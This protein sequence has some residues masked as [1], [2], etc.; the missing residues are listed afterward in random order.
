MN[1]DQPMSRHVRRVTAC[2]VCGQN[3]WLEILSLGLMPLANNY[4]EPAPSYEHEPHFPLELMACR[5]CWLVTLRHI[6]DPEI[7]YRHYIYIS[8][9]S[10]M[11]VRHMHQLAA[12]TI[13]RFGVPAGSL[14]VELGSNI[15]TQLEVFRDAGMRVLGIDPARNLAE[16]A[17]RKGIET[18]PEFFNAEL[19]G[20]IVQRFGRPFVILGRH[21]FA[22]IDNLRDVL[23][24][25]RAS[26]DRGGVF[27]IEV[28][29][30]VDLVGSNQFDTI[31]HE[32]LSYFSVGTFMRLFDRHGL[33][34]VDVE[35]FPVHGGSIVVFGALADSERP[36]N[37]SISDL[38]ALER[39]E[40]LAEEGYYRRFAERVEVT[41][42]AVARIVRGL[43]GG[44]K[45]VAGYGAPAKGNTLLN[46]CGLDNRALEYVSD[47][48]EFK[49]G[50]VL[51][52]THIPIKSPVYAKQHPPDCFLLLAW[53]YAKEIIGREQEY[54]KDG[55]TFIIPIPEPVVVSADSLLEGRFIVPTGPAGDGQLWTMDYKGIVTFNDGEIQGVAFK[56]LTVHRDSRGGLAELFRTDELS[57]EFRPEMATVSWTEP[58]AIRGPHEHL[59]QSNLLVFP[60]QQSFR[61][62]LWDNRETSPTY[63]HTLRRVVGGDRPISVLVPAGVVHAFQNISGERGLSLNFP[64]RLFR[65]EQRR[66][67]DGAIRHE[68]DQST[69]FKIGT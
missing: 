17:D 12:L 37:Q 60:G 56:P 23:A 49:Q 34:V 58:Q 36:A 38:L 18:W 51:P 11:I 54:L 55:G 64:N 59:D 45:R 20:R 33:R 3:D 30:L 43:A 5:S 24:G 68:Q 28:P 15:G 48:T 9:D 53:N 4:L 69:P 44:G 52:G 32:H 27:A 31:Y 66:A 21:V 46:A 19:A 47:T 26:L 62:T 63:R 25:V 42:Q 16:I 29:Y 35:R 14:V 1:S 10:K 65:G 22:H 61:L 57:M 40:G 8:S 67:D 39:R 6:I 7:L 41:R 2:R 50:R 13:Q